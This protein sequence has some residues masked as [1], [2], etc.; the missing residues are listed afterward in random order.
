MTSKGVQV[1]MND[2]RTF[3]GIKANVGD[4]VKISLPEGKAQQTIEFEEGALA[5]VTKG[6]HCSQ[7]ATI[8]GEQ[9]T[10]VSYC[11]VTLIGEE[12]GKK[13]KT[14][15][16]I[17]YED[18]FVKENNNWLIKKRKSMFDWQSKEELH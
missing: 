2:G 1:T 11:L 4:S 14:T 18:E 9:A 16:G 12:N 15:F 6:A 5:L 17:H 8:K 7:I 3:T 10:A 13:I